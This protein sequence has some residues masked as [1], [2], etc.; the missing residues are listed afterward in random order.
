MNEVFWIQGEPAVK[1]AIVL[2]PR[3][4]EWLEDEMRRIRSA[5]VGVLVSFLEP[6]E[7]TWLGLAQERAAAE[8][9][10]MEFISYPVPDVHVPRDAAGFG[11]FIAGL[12]DR[13]RRGQAIGVHCRG[14]IGRSTVAGACALVH[15]GW[16]PQAALQA[17]EAARGCPVPDTCEQRE[18]ILNYAAGPRA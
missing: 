16:T 18:W 15:M 17:I 11:K 1:L 4:E 6:E 13:L 2:R 14:S 7:A 3:G 5:G 10:G 9:A 12:A 8:R